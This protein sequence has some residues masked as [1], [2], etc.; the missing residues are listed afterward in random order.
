MPS[1]LPALSCWRA[2][3]VCVRNSPCRAAVGCSREVGQ[4]VP[5]RASPSR[6]LL[7]AMGSGM[8][9]DR[10]LKS[11][12]SWGAHWAQ[13]PYG[14]QLL[15]SQHGTGGRG[16]VLVVS[17]ISSLAE[18]HNGRMGPWG[19]ITSPLPEPSDG[20]A[21]ASRAERAFTPDPPCSGLLLLSQLTVGI[22][23]LD[24][25]GAL[26]MQLLGAAAGWLESEQR[27]AELPTELHPAGA[28]PSEALACGCCGRCYLSSPSP[29]A[30]LV[31][32]HRALPLPLRRRFQQG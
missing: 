17:N 24:S 18:T 32:T 1:A 4:R 27:G 11:E 10:R 5:Q 30:R 6:V 16:D 3:D 28:P 23:E 14:L 8:C 13:G 2:A 9:S 7:L 20:E 19:R 29:C 12:G 21:A 31:V 22:G 26:G 15:A 25:T